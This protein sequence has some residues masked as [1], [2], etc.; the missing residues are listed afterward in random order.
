MFKNPWIHWQIEPLFVAYPEYSVVGLLFYICLIN[1]PSDRR[2]LPDS[3]R[4]PSKIIFFDRCRLASLMQKLHG[5]AQRKGFPRA[6]RAAV[7]F[8][9]GSPATRRAC[10]PRNRRTHAAPQF[11]PSTNVLGGVVKG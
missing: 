4:L 1:I 5:Q 10:T 7:S 11:D 8:R 2:I 9:S 6:L 3:Q